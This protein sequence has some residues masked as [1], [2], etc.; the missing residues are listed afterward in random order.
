M[1]KQQCFLSGGHSYGVNDIGKQTNIEMGKIRA[2]LNFKNQV[3]TGSVSAIHIL[4]H[5]PAVLYVHNG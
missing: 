1:A 2:C 5:I 4:L 3:L